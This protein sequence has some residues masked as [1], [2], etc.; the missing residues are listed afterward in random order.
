MVKGLLYII[1]K[2][3][4]YSCILDQ[5]YFY[6][7]LE[8]LPFQAHLRQNGRL[9]G[10]L[11]E[12][13]NLLQSLTP[14]ESIAWIKEVFV[15]LLQGELSWETD[16]ENALEKCGVN[17]KLSNDGKYM[18]LMF[19]ISLNP[20]PHMAILGSSNSAANKDMMSKIR[21]NVDTVI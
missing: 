20:L 5:D 9:S 18:R 15:G 12:E 17:V 14:E 1:N 6:L 19:E 16:I 10:S 11:K 3:K 4:L 13:I 8:H 2:K 7:I 21:T